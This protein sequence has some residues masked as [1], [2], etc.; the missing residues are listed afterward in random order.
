[1]KK[2]K[3]FLIIFALSILLSGIAYLFNGNARYLIEG[4]ELSPLNY[5]IGLE[6][7]KAAFFDS[8]FIWLD[9]RSEEE[10][11]DGHIAGAESFPVPSPLSRKKEFFL[12]VPKDQFIITYCVRKSCPAAKSLAM[13]LRYRGYKNCFVYTGGWEEWKEAGMPVDAAEEGK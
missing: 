1:M 11:K 2:I 10:Y 8:R 4:V 6:K 3:G 9:A 7:A 12:R 5:R 13:E